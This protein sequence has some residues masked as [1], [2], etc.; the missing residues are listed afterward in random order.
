MEA[1]LVNWT[2]RVSISFGILRLTY[3]FMKVL[4]CKQESIGFFIMI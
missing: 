4:L 2:R 1:Y 3:F